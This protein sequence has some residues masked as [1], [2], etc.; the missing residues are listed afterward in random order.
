MQ[1]YLQEWQE[2]CVDEQLTRL[3]V[4]AL[5]GDRPYDYLFYAD[6]IPRRNDGRIRNSLLERY[7]HLEDGGWWC[8]GIDILTGDNDLWGCFKPISPR[9]S[10]ERHKPIKYEHPPQTSTGVFALKVPQH[11][12]KSISERYNQP[13]LSEDIDTEQPDAGFWQWL[14]KYP[15]IP[16]CI[17]EG[18]KKAGALLTAGYAA[19]ALPG[20]NGGYRVPRN[21]FGD[22]P[23]ERLRQRIGKARL[24]PQLQKLAQNKRP[25]YIV[26]DRDTKPNTVKAVNA[27][28]R[29]TG[30]LLSQQKCE[31]KVITWHPDWGKGVDDL[32][33]HKGLETFDRAYEIA[34]T[35][36]TWK[37]VAFNQ[38]TYPAHYQFNCRYLDELTIPKQARLIGIKS[39]KGTG[40]T[41]FLESIVKQA[42]AEKKWVLAIGH[43]VRLVESLCKRFGLNYITEVRDDESKGILGYGLCIDSLHP[44][45]QGKFN[46]ANWQ[47]GIVII[48]EVEQVLWHGL[49]SKTCQGNRVSILK[50]LKTLMQNV[51]GGEGQVYVADADLTDVSLDYLISLA[52]V[53]L[54]PFI[55]QNDWQPDRDNAWEVY[56]YPDEAPD[57]LVRDLEAHIADGGKPFVCLSAQKLKSQWGT[58]NLEAYLKEKFPKSKILRIDS[59]SLVDPTHASYG[60]M[61]DLDGFLSEYDIVLASPSIETGVS[62]DLRG[63]FTSVWA[64]A[65]G[66]QSENSVRQAIGRIRENVPRYLWIA[67]FGFN[68]VGNGSTSIPALLGSGQRLTQLN[69]RLLQQSDFAALD[70]LETGFQAESLLCWAKFAVRFNVAMLEYRK[71]ILTALLAEGHIVEEKEEEKKKKR[72]EKE[73]K[74]EKK[75]IDG[76]KAAIAEVRDRNYQEECEAIA[77][78]ADISDREYQIL[79]K[80]LVKTYPQRRKLRKYELFQRYSIDITPDLVVKDDNGWYAQLRLHYFLTVGRQYLADRDAAKAKQL[81]AQGEGKIFAPD[82]NRSQLGAKIGTMEVLGLSVLLDDPDRELRNSDSDLKAMQKIAIDNRAF[83]K[84]V[85]GIGIAKNASPVLIMRRFLEQIGYGVKCIKCEGKRSQDKKIKRTTRTRVYKVVLPDDGRLAVFS[86]WLNPVLIPDGIEENLAIARRLEKQPENEQN[87]SI[88]L[89]LF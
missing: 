11:L 32:I 46:A 81:L 2:S 55:I 26:F 12:W 71:T 69:V 48:D 5:E 59:E 80:Q 54:Q 17:T 74:Q 13:I 72:G 78:A 34:P 9:V 18:A 41:Q 87:N 40:K 75:E 14:M 27:A 3:N 19:I 25:I 67:P 29:Q 64:I 36:E 82:F 16:L 66:I 65:Q 35:L 88:Q 49:N 38:L 84:T 58:R 21:E 22:S 86:Q 37:A 20:V 68:Q 1:N 45:S 39:P 63:H 79:K 70:D 73:K 42:I 30:Y 50:S 53:N 52:G 10:L 15:Q 61:N 60:C 76:L 57:R 7:Q 85:L 23:S 28:I 44:N 6:S 47:D 43:R 4:T 89:S 77:L 8:S 83:I 33:S 51:L 24:I 62:I 56:H 31:V